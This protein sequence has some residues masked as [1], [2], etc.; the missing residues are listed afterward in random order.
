MPHFVQFLYLLRI[1]AILTEDPCFV[2]EPEL[3]PDDEEEEEEGFLGPTR[4]V[5]IQEVPLHPS[6]QYQ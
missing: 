1:V 4:A 6:P 2:Q 3:E 5:T